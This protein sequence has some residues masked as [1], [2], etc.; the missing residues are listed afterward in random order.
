MAQVRNDA[1]KK[2]KFDRM[3]RIHE[4]EN[5]FVSEAMRP[6]AANAGHIK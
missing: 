2:L 4:M 1:F 6:V 5:N 3:D